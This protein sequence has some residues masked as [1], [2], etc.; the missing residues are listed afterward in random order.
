MAELPEIFKL[1]AQMRDTLSGVLFQTHVPFPAYLLLK[2][3]AV[4]LR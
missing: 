3:H 2:L 4:A 1:A